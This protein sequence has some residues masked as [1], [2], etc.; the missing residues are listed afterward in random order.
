MHRSVFYVYILTGN[1]LGRKKKKKK[2]GP[3]ACTTITTTRKFFTIL[4]SVFL[5]EDNKL[6][7]YQ[8]FGVVVVFVGLSFEIV[9]KANSN[10]NKKHN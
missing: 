8:W 3:L 1:K 9:F 7:L 4:L 5:H 10:Q 6:T 2:A